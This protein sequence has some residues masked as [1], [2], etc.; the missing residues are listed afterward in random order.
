MAENKQV[1]QNKK[2]VVIIATIAATGG[3]LFGFDTGVISGAIPFL[4]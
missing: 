3:L 4:D 1:K 2:L